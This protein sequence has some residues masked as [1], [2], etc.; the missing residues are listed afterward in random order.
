MLTSG[1]NGK[2]QICCTVEVGLPVNV[3]PKTRSWL[4]TSCLGVMVS[5]TWRREGSMLGSL[6][7]FSSSAVTDVK[8]ALVLGRSRVLRGSVV[9]SGREVERSSRGSSMVL[10]VNHGDQTQRWDDICMGLAKGIW[11]DC[12]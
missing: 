12:D 5:V 6:A 2:G 1:F 10:S 3:L 7:R 9:R 8:I 4:G 11:I